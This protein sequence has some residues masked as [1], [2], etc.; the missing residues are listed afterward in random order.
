MPLPNGLHYEWTLK[1]LKAGKHVLLEK[2][3]TSNAEEAKALFRHEILQQPNAPVVLEA[4]HVLFHPAFQ[5]FISLLDQ[6][7]IASAKVTAYVP[8]GLFPK[9]DIRFIYDLSGGTLMDLGTYDVLALRQIF[10][11]EPEECIEAVPRLMPKGFDQ[12]CD[13]SMHATFRFPNGGTGE[14]LC[15]LAARGGYPLSWLTGSLPSLRLPKCSVVHREVVVQDPSL[16][17]DSGLEHVVVKSV[18]MSNFMAPQFWHRIEVEEAHT[19]RHA[20]TKAVQKQWNEKSSHVGYT[21]PKTAAGEGVRAGEEYWTTYRYQLEA[22]VDRVKGRSG[23]GVWMDGE[24]S[25]AQMAMIDSAYQKAG[26]PLRPTS[27]YK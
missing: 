1:A 14:L 18:N 22:F 19:I 26:L 24:Y 2:P 7:N 13:E 11:T 16:A 6:P 17:A 27:T 5:L 23:S 25:I 10:G 8:G 4:F 15:D 3:S 20:T 12:N 21:W 9:D